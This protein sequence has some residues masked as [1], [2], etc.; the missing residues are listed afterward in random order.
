MHNL[1]GLVAEAVDA[2]NLE[3]LAVEEDLEHTYGIASDLCPCGVLEEGLC[4]FVRHLGG[5]QLAFGLAH[6]ADLGNGVDAGRHVIDEAEVFIEQ[7]VACVAALVVGGTGKA[8]PAD[9]VA[10]RIDMRDGGAVVVVD[11]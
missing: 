4:H 11:L 1:G 7:V 2:E 8:R 9:Y 5:G 10:Y 3:A 6:R